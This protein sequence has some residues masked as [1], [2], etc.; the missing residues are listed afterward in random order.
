MAELSKLVMGL[1][2]PRPF[3]LLRMQGTAL[4]ASHASLLGETLAEGGGGGE[5]EER[6]F[7]APSCC[8]QV[9]SSGLVCR[10][11]YFRAPHP[12]VSTSE[13]AAPTGALV[14]SITSFPHFPSG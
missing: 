11:G 12:G 8:C 7:L 2:P 1:S 14:L 9:F 13:D 3:P 4:P 6:V 10:V 5:G